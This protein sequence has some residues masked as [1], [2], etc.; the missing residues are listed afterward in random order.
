[1]CAYLLK[2]GRAIELW[3]PRLERLDLRLR[4]GCIAERGSDLTPVHDEMVLDVSGKLVM[5]GLTCAH[6]HLYS[7]LARGMPAPAERPRNFLEILEKIWWRLDRALDEETLYASALVGA[8]EAARAGTTTIIDHNSSPGFIRGSL[9]TVARALEEV[10]LRGILCYEVTDRGGPADRDAGLDEQRDFL[11]QL[12]S[13]LIRGMVGGHASFTLGDE[14]LEHLRRLAQEFGTGVHIHVAEDLYDVEHARREYRKRPTE[15]LDEAGLL[16]PR[17]LL[18][19]GTHCDARD[20]EVLQQ[21]QVWLVHNPRSNMNNA[22]GYAPVTHAGGQVALGTDGIG[23]DMFEE[24]R[25][26]FFRSQE[27]QTG[28]G[29]EGVVSLLINGSRFASLY[30]G[31]PMGTLAVGAAA[32][33]VILDYT[34]PTPLHSGNVPWHFIFGMGAH[35][36]QSVLVAGR[37]IVAN[38]RFCRVDEQAVYARARAAAQRLWQMMAEIP[39][40]VSGGRQLP[41]GSW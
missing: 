17:S 40:L 15:R 39:E 5:P 2:G 20:L 28:L 22:V 30:F 4:D 10:G 14:T 21:Q 19:H 6:T 31:Q 16:V 34:P 29:A 26:A 38:R 11:G 27:E 7:A 12:S 18:A 25:V 36:V 13:P 1:M 35:Q 23:A 9:R 32:D 37:L 33:L 24:A 3:P 41:A 8:L